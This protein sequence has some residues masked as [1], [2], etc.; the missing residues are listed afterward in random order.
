MNAFDQVR[1]QTLSVW[2][3]LA[4]SQRLTL[5][6]VVAL[7]VGA[8]GWMMVRET[9][10]RRVPLFT[11][12]AFSV[13]ESMNAQDIL[14]AAGLTDFE[15]RG[16]QLYVP[17][18]DVERYSAALVAGGGLPMN[19]AE[20][21][22]KQNS[23]LGQFTGS[24][25]REATKEMARGKQ[26]ARLLTQIPDIAWADVVWD[27]DSRPGWRT[28]PK[29]RATVSLRAVPGRS[30]T[31]KLVLAARR[32]VAGSKKHLAP[33]D[34]VVIDV[35]T[36]DSYD[37][38]ENGEF[39]DKVL[40]RMNQLETMYRNKILDTLDYIDG[41][42]VAVNVTLDK[43]ESSRRRS[44]RVNP[45]EVLAVAEDTFSSEERSQRSNT[46]A[47]PGAGPNAAIDLQNGRNPGQTSSLDEQTGSIIQTA[48]F[49]ITEDQ[50]VGLLPQAVTVAV[51]IPKEHYRMVALRSAGLTGRK[52]LTEDEIEAVTQQMEAEYAPK[53][54]QRIRMML[55]DAGPQATDDDVVKVDTFVKPEQKDALESL[56]I[57][58]TVADM[59]RTWG[60]PVALILLSL[61]ALYVVN[62]SL[63]RPLPDLPPMP[64]PP[65]A[66]A[67]AADGG[68]SE[69]AELEDDLPLLRPPDNRK[70]EHLQ[71]VVRDNPELAA[72]VVASWVSER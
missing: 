53:I 16:S 9:G 3:S 29:A 39:G 64:Q 10:D 68:D 56:P 17:V 46:L 22:E 49:E 48:S 21:W 1:T 69:A 14:A 42:R 67:S 61:A 19:W 25:E 2:Q 43:I 66:A 37:G 36:G 28:A 51:S 71:T 62:Q 44:Q 58:W 38:H 65:A 59:V 20:E 27:E 15:Q 57:T 26:V 18:G 12:K 32:A 30:I 8:F 7:L 33:E 45:K 50:I 52:D 23:A 60:R 41:V 13:E 54:Q 34:V 24:L 72:S 55:P 11:G 47:E 70:R 31:P 4:T 35:V 40:A 6:V 5:G 63:K